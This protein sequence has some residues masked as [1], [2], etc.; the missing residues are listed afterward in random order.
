[1][2]DTLQA[3]A[4]AIVAGAC[5]LLACLAFVRTHRHGIKMHH[6]MAKARQD[7][8]FVQW[9]RWTF[10]SITDRDGG[11]FY[12]SLHDLRDGPDDLIWG[13]PKAVILFHAGPD[14]PDP[15]GMESTSG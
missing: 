5:V 1:M 3:Y 4:P 2:T 11:L 15:Y 9:A 10:L 6:A 8:Q 12:R 14:E 7:A 13:E